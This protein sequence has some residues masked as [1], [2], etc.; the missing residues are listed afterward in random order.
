MTSL[1]R[2]PDD[3][4]LEQL[5]ERAVVQLNDTHPTIGIAEL[6]RLLVDEYQ[7]AWEPAW[8]I[9]RQV[10]AYTCHTLLP[11][12]LEKWPVALFEQLLPRHLQIIYEVNARFLEGVRKRYPADAARIAR[13]SIIEEEPVRQVRMAHLAVVGGYKVNGVAPLQSALLRDLVLKD[14]SDYWPE[15]FT[16]VTNGVTPRR[17]IRLANPHLADLITETIGEGWLSDLDELKRLEPHAEDAA[18]R[19]RW[20]EIKRQNKESLAEIIQERT[21]TV[22]PA[23][24]LFDVMAKRLHE[25][26]RQLLK[27]LHIIT[28]YHRIKSGKSGKSGKTATPVPRVV[29]FGAKA[30][31]SYSMAKLIIK[32]IHN[33]GDIINTDPDV[34][35]KLKVVFLPNFN[36]TVAERIYPAADLSEQI[37]LAGKEASGTGNMKFALNGALTI[38]TLDGANVDIL[39]R[40]GADNFFLFGLSVEEVTALLAAGYEPRSY[41]ARNPELKQALDQLAAG[42]FSPAQPDLFR[43]IVDALLNRDEYLL[44]ADYQ[45]YVDRQ[46]EVDKAY[47]DTERWTRMSILNTARCG[48]FSSDRSMQDY[49]TEIWHV[50]PVDVPAWR[51]ARAAGPSEDGRRSPGLPGLDLTEAEWQLLATAPTTV[52]GLMTALVDQGLIGT[53]SEDGSIAV[54]PSQ[55]A[56]SFPG[57]SLIQAVL[58]RMREQVR[59]ARARSRAS[60]QD[61]E[62]GEAAHSHPAG[63]AG[64]D[65]AIQM[66]IEVADLLAR[67]VPLPQAAEFKSWLLAIAETT[68]DAGVQGPGQSTDGGSETDVESRALSA[69][70]GALRV[71]A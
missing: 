10:F 50:N 68:A 67:K 48:Y 5:P 70:A 11:E 55:A 25:Y 34:G 33:V 57:N 13:M 63:A 71:S 26:K 40:V 60:A 24:A 37:S 39:E 3:V 36:V 51:Q 69:L 22:V 27:A 41:Y 19:T 23:D 12:A 17:F 16:N 38:G 32:L 14:F 66:C 56:R 49:A 45:D 28:L 44:L 62:E 59:L 9:T 43:P 46:D 15:K 1:R 52:A 8:D 65:S 47:G 6:M 61:P 20:R 18:F 64:L 4:P 2:L 58:G 54:G 53:L 7:M 31:P 35:D 21:G 29:C 30:A 42:A